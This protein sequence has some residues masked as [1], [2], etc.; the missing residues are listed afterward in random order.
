MRLFSYYHWTVAT[1]AF[2]K[3]YG[4]LNK[5][6]VDP[7]KMSRWIKFW[8]NNVSASPCFK[9]S[10][11]STFIHNKKIWLLTQ[12]VYKAKRESTQIK[13]FW[14]ESGKGLCRT[15]GSCFVRAR[16]ATT[17]RGLQQAKRIKTTNDIEEPEFLTW[18]KPRCHY[19]IKPNWFHVSVYLKHT[20][21]DL[22]ARL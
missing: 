15:W 14:Q 20:S 19:D 13:R 1:P 21:S 10:P 9:F 17:T 8:V 11:V 7:I 6:F 18:S 2:L 12:P 5:T 22:Y 3:K 4:V 16:Y